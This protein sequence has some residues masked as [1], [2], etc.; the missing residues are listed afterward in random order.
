MRVVLLAML[1]MA[2]AKL[3]TKPPRGWRSW[4][5]LKQDAD[6]TLMESAIVA[7]TK[8]RA[9]GVSLLD[10]GY[11]DVGLDG[12]W[13]RCDGV[14]GGNHDHNG[15]ILTNETKFPDFRAM[16]AKAHAN[17]LTSSWYLNCDQCGKTQ[18]LNESA[19]TDT[20]YQNDANQA[21][22]LDFDGVKF[23]T[24]PEGPNWNI[25]KWSEALA[26]TGKDFV[27]EDCLDKHPDG[28]PLAK[29]KPGWDHPKI[30]ILHHPEYCPFSF[31]RTGGDNV[32]F[33][34][35]RCNR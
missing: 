27:I 1:A 32:R 31:Y 26:A 14:D 18:H 24:Q 29:G 5:A 17:G 20:F 13:S 23:D 30:D 21:A 10:L 8:K 34:F 11:S 6:Q 15:R 16:N 9:G 35:A 28:E 7:M 33:R 25:S 2:S 12:G 3:A 22:E 19:F 4:I